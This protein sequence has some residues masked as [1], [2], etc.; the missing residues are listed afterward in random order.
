MTRDVTREPCPDR[1][2]EDLGAAFAMGCIGGSIFNFVKGIYNSPSG[3]RLS[4]GLYN[5]RLRAP[6]TGGNFAVW[7]GLFSTFDC[8]F[9]YMRKKDDHWNAIAS[10]FTTGY[11]CALR[12]GWR[13]ACVSA[14]FGG[15]IIAVME[16]VGAV[17]T[18]QSQTTPR[19]QF[20]QAMEYEKMQQK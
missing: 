19:A 20:Y 4:G 6:I 10:G 16:A 11:V 7:G 18:R 15:T 14:M 9:Q 5:A 1:I 3:D 13:N 2:V 17:F 8:T 12:G